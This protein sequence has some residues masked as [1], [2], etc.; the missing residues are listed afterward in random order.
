MSLHQLYV[1]IGDKSHAELLLSQLNDLYQEE[2]DMKY[3]VREAMLDDFLWDLL[4]F[5]ELSSPKI[6]DI[7]KVFGR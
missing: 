7:A 5:N 2:N 3:L 1:K 4:D 6:Q